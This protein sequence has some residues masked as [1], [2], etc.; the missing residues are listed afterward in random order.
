MTKP[1]ADWPRFSLFYL[2]DNCSNDLMKRT[3]AEGSLWCCS[4]GRPE[5]SMPAA[6]CITYSKGQLASCPN[7]ARVVILACLVIANIVF[8]NCICK[9]SGACCLLNMSSSR[10][11][12]AENYRC[13]QGTQIK[14]DDSLRIWKRSAV[15]SLYFD[16][17]MRVEHHICSILLLAAALA[18]IIQH[19]GYR[20]LHVLQ[21]FFCTFFQQPVVLTCMHTVVSVL[22]A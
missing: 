9:S 21:M 13:S 3:N 5:I 10:Q 16:N 15:Q 12:P 11:R 2:C 7:T 17:A 6:V 22:Y 14:I 8:L 19:Y 4:G 1:A 20:L 18:A